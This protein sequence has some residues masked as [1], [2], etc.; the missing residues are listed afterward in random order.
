MTKIANYAFNS[1]AFRDEID[2][3]FVAIANELK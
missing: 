1:D 3:L 2:A